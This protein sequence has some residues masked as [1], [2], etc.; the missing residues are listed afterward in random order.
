MDGIPFQRTGSGNGFQAAYRCP[1][2]GGNQKLAAFDTGDQDPKKRY[3]VLI[4]TRGEGGYALVP[5]SLHPDTHKHYRYLI[6]DF[7][8]LPLISQDRRDSILALARSLTEKKAD[9]RR[10]REFVRPTEEM[11]AQRVE[12]RVVIE[13]YNRTTP[14]D[15]VLSSVGYSVHGEWAVRP[16]GKRRTVK[17]D[18]GENRSFHN[19]S[20]DPMCDG[21]GKDGY[22]KRPFDFLCYERGG[23]FVTALKDAANMIGVKLITTRS[24]AEPLPTMPE[25][26]VAPKKTRHNL[27]IVT[28]YHPD[29]AVCERLGIPAVVSPRHLLIPEV[30]AA[31]EPFENRIFVSA[32]PEDGFAD[33]LA[34]DLRARLVHIPAHLSTLVDEGRVTLIDLVAMIRGAIHPVWRPGLGGM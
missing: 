29:L 28:D 24:R 33:A 27:I 8:D 20:N 30:V 3:Q 26:P 23:D 4:E 10:V 2:P 31:V 34:A 6:G 25:K 17:I 15:Y 13:E 22:W 14:I 9:E 32:P 5:P 11:T 21:N 7:V 19:A 1:K 12:A 18:Y 16:G